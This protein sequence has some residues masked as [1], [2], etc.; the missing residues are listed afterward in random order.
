MYESWTARRETPD[1][2]QIQGDES[3]SYEA[4]GHDC[5]CPGGGSVAAGFKA[6][7]CEPHDRAPLHRDRS[8]PHA[9]THDI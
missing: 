9:H 2:A 6:G 4:I 5:H 7:T 8:A 3:P 1:A